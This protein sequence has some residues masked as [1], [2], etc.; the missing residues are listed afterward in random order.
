MMGRDQTESTGEPCNLA[1]GHRALPWHL[2]DL[3]K[4]VDSLSLASHF[5]NPVS[6]GPV[7]GGRNRA[8]C[9]HSCGEWG[10]RLSH[11]MNFSRQEQPYPSWWRHMK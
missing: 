6:L 3:I 5:Y 2:V 4:Y 9:K 10:K 11:P 8:G 1:L 7:S